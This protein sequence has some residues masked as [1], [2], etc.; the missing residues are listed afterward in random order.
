MIN[1]GEVCSLLANRQ[2]D[3][4]IYLINEESNEV[5]LPNKYI[6]EG[7]KMG[8]NIEVYIYKDSE[9]RI[10]ATNLFPKIKL[11][12]YAALEVK[13]ISKIGVFFDW[14]L[15]KEL[16]VPFSQLLESVDVGEYYVV[17]MYHDKVSDRLVGTTKINFT[18]ERNAVDLEVGDKVD[19][20]AYEETEIGISVIVDNKYQG[21]LFKNEIFESFQIGDELT[22]YVKKIR[23][24]DNKVDVSL[25][26]FGYRAV[27]ENVNKLLD[28]LNFNSGELHLHD[29][30]SPEDIADQLGM[31]KKIFKKAVGFLYREKQ[32][33]MTKTGIKLIR[34]NETQGE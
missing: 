5:L 17:Y 15:E 26:P 34:T 28:A 23:E 24:A 11:N 16:L 25:N 4:G 8:D 18:L 30:S 22:G 1:L 29:K 14:G 7:L 2:T 12:S 13:S 21:M 9:D 31:S 19:L 32:I 20:L 10:I 3:N 27:D 6:P 33:E